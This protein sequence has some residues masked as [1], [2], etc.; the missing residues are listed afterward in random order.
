MGGEEV[1]R[2]WKEE[3]EGDRQGV[4][5]QKGLHDWEYALQ[6]VFTIVELHPVSIIKNFILLSSKPSYSHC[7]LWPVP[8]CLTFLCGAVMH[9]KMISHE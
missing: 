5:K 1:G 9:S 7:K 8:V 2:A 6:L 3:G 4:T